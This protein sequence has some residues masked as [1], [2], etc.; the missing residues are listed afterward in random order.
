M[1]S[2]FSPFDI[3]LR[4]GRALQ[5]RPMRVSDEAELVQAFERLSPEAR[6]MR[7]MRAVREPNVERLRKVLASFPETGFGIVATVPAADGFD[8]VGSA[9]FILGSNPA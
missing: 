7:F 3:T 9:I 2:G 1:D 6:Y 8:I 4:D 5:I